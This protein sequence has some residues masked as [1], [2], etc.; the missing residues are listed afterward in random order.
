MLQNGLLNAKSSKIDFLRV[1]INVTGNL[2]KFQ[3]T[4]CI[5]NT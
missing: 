4:Q 3:W 2:P 5:Q 1:K